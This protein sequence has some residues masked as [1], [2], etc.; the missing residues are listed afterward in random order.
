MPGLGN[1]SLTYEFE[2]R[3]TSISGAVTNSSL[4]NGDGLR[5]RKTDSSG[6][7]AYVYDGAAFIGETSA[8]GT[9][10]AYYL[11]GIGLVRPATDTR[12]FHAENAHGRT[13]AVT[14]NAGVRQSRYLYDGYGVT[15]TVSRAL[16]T[17]YQYGGKHG[18]YNDGD[19]G[20]LLLG[21]R[22]YLPKLGRFLT[23][24]PLKPGT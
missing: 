7:T 18:Y 13:L 23:Q 10:T 8:S 1:I 24:D 16:W 17:P 15:Y 3:V 12:A 4:Y 2:N 20:M 19:T 22:D 14:D 9:I 5:V 21:Y 6:T 11:P